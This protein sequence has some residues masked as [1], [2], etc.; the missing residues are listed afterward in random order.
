MAGNECIEADKP[1]DQLSTVQVSLPEGLVWTELNLLSNTDTEELYTLLSEN[2]VED[3]DSFFRF[4]YPPHFLEWALCPP[5]WKKAWHLGIKDTK[6]TTEGVAKLVG[7]IS[8]VPI[9]LK[10]DNVEKDMAEVNFLCL[11]KSLRS[12]RLSPLLIQEITRRVHLQGNMFQA[13][14]TAGVQLTPAVS[15][16]R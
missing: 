5:G 12:K 14:F 8:A 10:V 3:G 4:N 2:Y 7:F 13:I 16:G 15:T 11:H 6:H 9:R 1:A